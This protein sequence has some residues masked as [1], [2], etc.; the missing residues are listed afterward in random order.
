MRIRVACGAL[1]AVLVWC[2]PAVADSASQVA[3]W[4]EAARVTRETEADIQK[5][6]ILGVKTHVEALENALNEGS[7]V[8]PLNPVADGTVTILTDGAMEAIAA[9]AAA[10]GAKQK[11]IAVANPYPAIGLYLGVY[12]NEIGKPEDALRV[13]DLGLK[14][15]SSDLNLGAHLPAL[16]AEKA[17]SLE[18]LKRFADGLQACETGLALSVMDDRDRARL[19]RCRAFNLV[20]LNRLDDAEASYRQSLKLD[21]GNP[22]A[23]KELDYIARLRTGQPR[24]PTEQIL[25]PVSPPP[26]QPPQRPASNG[27]QPT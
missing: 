20:E 12:Y 14:L 11:A 9:L 25:P 2:L 26:A 27:L 16:Y 4:T 10:A 23:L 5:D 13:L 22:L 17:A 6:G 24:A 7:K 8:F 18:D 3:P 1:F 21:P 19:Y 15:T